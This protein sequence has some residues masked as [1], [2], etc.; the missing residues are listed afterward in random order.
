MRVWI[1][2][3]NPPQVQYLTPFC[4]G[5][6]AQGHDVVVTARR[7]PTTLELL[8]QRSIEAIAIGGTGG[9]STAQKV[10]RVGTRA[11]RLVGRFAPRRPDLLVA[12]SRSS[13]L[14]AWGLRLPSFCFC[15]YEYVDLRVARRTDTYVVHPDVI[16]TEAFVRAGIERE[17]LLPFPALK[18]AISFHGVDVGAIQPLSLPSRNG[19]PSLRVLFRPPGEETHYFVPESRRLA[20]ELLGHLAGRAD[21]VTVY[22]PRYP[23]QASYLDRFPWVNTPV[24]LKEPAP[25]VALL[26]AVDVVISSGGTMLREAA[27]LG[28]P[29]YSILRSRIGQVDRHLESI[30]RLTILE[31]PAEFE[32]IR[33]ERAQLRPLPSRSPDIVGELV[34]TMLDRVHEHGR[35]SSA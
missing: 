21:V 17:R 18:E 15:D 31:S 16:D 7:D 26:K 23:H 28:I 25:F 14:A 4:D 20:L 35:R 12:A 33:V 5:F 2:I 8:G 30:G 6:V 1:D 27:Y 34:G 24:L 19:G 3:E 29:A 10:L 13:P 22:S 32:G 11:T 9:R